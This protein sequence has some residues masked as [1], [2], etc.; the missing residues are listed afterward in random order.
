M[1]NEHILTVGDSKQLP[2]L[3][4][5]RFLKGHREPRLAMV[6]R[7]NVGKSSLIN[8]L[9][10]RR[11][12]QVSNEPGKTR[13]IHFYK[14]QEGKKII[15]DLPGYGFAKT[16]HAEREKWARF[17]NEY[18]KADENLERAVVL[19]D[20][21]H[22]PTP[23]DLEAIDFLSSQGIPVTFVFT[24]SDGLKTQ[25]DRARRRREASEA[26][27]KLGAIPEDAHWVSVKTRDG[28]KKLTED[29]S[30]PSS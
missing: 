27:K 3:L 7:S 29:L 21:R 23:L 10:G 13:K 28:L 19:L 1:P 9:L 4:N 15:A 5:E 20:S 30:C 2:D 6:G 14:W 25:S 22:G 8:A 26:L 17:I 24:K 16:G 12:A 11:L 18:L